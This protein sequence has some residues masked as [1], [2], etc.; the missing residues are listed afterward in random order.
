MTIKDLQ[1]L[2]EQ[3]QHQHQTSSNSTAIQ[4]LL[5][6]LRDRP[7]YYWIKF[8]SKNGAQSFNGI[9]GLPKKNG[10]PL[11]LFDYQFMIYKALM[12][13][14]YFNKRYPS[15]KEESYFD[16]KRADVESTTK[17]KD[18]NTLYSKA[19]Y[20]RE[21]DNTLLYPFKVKHVWIKKA[22][23][24]G[25]TEFMLRYM[26]WLCL[27]NDDYKNSQMVI[28]T[29]P[30]Q[31]LA[32][33]CIK[34]IKALFEPH[35]IT[36]D[37]KE[38]VINLNGCE[39]QA[40]PSNH[41]DSFRSLTNPKFILLDEA[42]FFRKSEQEEVRHVAE[43]YIAKS[44]PFIVIISTPNRPDGL[45]AKIE[46][47]PFDTCIYKKVFLDYTYGLNKIYT[48]EEIEKAKMS[49]SFPREY[50]LQY[51]GLI[52]NVFSTQS[53]ENCQKIEY[54]PLTAT[55]NCKVSIGIDPSF[56]S[57]KFGIVATRF[58]NERIE[59]IEAEEHD[60]PD[61]NSMLDRVWQIKQHKVDD[62]NL[63][64]YVD[65]ANPEIWSALKRMLNETHS[66][67]YVFERLAYY[68]KNNINPANS[69]M[70][71]IPIAFSNNQGAKMLQHTKS[72][73]E[74]KDNLVVIDKRFDKLLT[75][76]RTA[77]ANEYKLDKEQTSY[78]DI[79]DAFRLSLQ[80]YQR[81]NK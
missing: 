55:P 51:Q 14:T 21:K 59:V 16:Q 47:E 52:G 26:A 72:L 13:P 65:A 71:V 34:R 6:K 4:D 25:I 75:S 38:T 44:D 33:K 35:G 24:L 22:T 39:I 17:I 18:Q 58:V 20:Q 53:I 78:H 63:T 31:E 1:R 80:L 76:L 10:K 27:R 49:P 74:D 5:N 77:V 7:F 81:S 9:I 37:S 73:L 64:I 68:K 12:E 36:F 61:F 50:E 62:N 28:I 3:H 54:N 2:M 11:P 30:N 42:D 66:E 40:Y 79:L 41:I 60:R 8:Q 57:S 46:K 15:P 48:I 43:R 70:K 19:L 67:Q 23:G 32:I 45:F 56:G 69:S 29:G